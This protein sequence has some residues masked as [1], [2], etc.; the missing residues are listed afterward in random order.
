MKWE[1]VANREWQ[2]VGKIGTFTITQSGRVFWARYSSTTKC[3]KMP[4]RG[5]LS[6][7]KGMCEDNGYWEE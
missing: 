2:A 7:A 5:K 3:F 6:E 1:K 4:P